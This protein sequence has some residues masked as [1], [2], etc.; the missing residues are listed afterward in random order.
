MRI[1]SVASATEVLMLDAVQK[2]RESERAAHTFA[3]EQQQLRNIFKRD[4]TSVAAHDLAEATDAG[5]TARDAE[6]TEVAHIRFGKHATADF[7]SGDL[8]CSLA[9]RY[10]EGSR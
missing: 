10:P 3:R 9:L 5:R 8:T 7:T 4:S 1:R 6:E 2:F